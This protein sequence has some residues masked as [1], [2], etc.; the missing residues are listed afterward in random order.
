ML[1]SAFKLVGTLKYL[2]VSHPS[3]RQENTTLLASALMRS[4]EST[5]EPIVCG[6]VDPA[7]SLTTA[8]FAVALERGLPC[9]VAIDPSQQGVGDSGSDVALG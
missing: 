2:G 9:E 1:L 7:G 4:V 5:A 6:T 3:L 8:E